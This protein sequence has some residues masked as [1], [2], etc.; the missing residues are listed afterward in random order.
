MPDFVTRTIQLARENVEQ[1][2]RPF[3][4]VI[5]RGDEIVAESPNLVAQTSD[6]TAH[7]EIVAI[8]AACRQLGTEHLSDCDIY[9]LAYPCPMCLGAL[10]Y[11]SPNQVIYNTT[12][13]Q[14]APHYV[15]DRRYF[16]LQTFYDEYAKHPDERAL[17]V[18]RE[19]CDDALAVYERWRELNSES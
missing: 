4:C 8:G 6:P 19:P 14:Y 5:A 7:A 11:C 3:A 12:R 16:T 9:V 1:G 2:G 10:Y 17:P 15:D 18:H 13:E